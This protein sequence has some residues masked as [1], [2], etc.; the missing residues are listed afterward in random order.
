MHS[1]TML[2]WN[3]LSLI[4]N[5]FLIKII[6][7]LKCDTMNSKYFKSSKLISSETKYF[8]FN[9]NQSLTTIIETP[10]VQSYKSET[11]VIIF[12]RKQN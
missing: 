4:T 12:A 9:K 10:S 7:H 1:L 2:H 5:T 6:L 3:W 8:I 11:S